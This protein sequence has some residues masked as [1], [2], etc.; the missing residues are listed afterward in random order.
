VVTQPP[1]ITVRFADETDI[2]AIAKLLAIARR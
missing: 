1:Q 2:I